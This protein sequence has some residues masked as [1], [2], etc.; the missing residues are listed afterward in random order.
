[1]LSWLL[2]NYETSHICADNPRPQ[3]L[4]IPH[5]DSLTRL[6]ITHFY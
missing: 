4:Y 2:V 1:M 5:K 6:R 3:L